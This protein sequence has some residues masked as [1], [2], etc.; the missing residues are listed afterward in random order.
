MGK[1][2]EPGEGQWQDA[3]TTS[4]AGIRDEAD[5]TRVVFEA[6]VVERGSRVASVGGVHHGVSEERWSGHRP[7]R[8]G[9]AWMG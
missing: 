9:A 6:R 3:E 5:A 7:G 8:T 1:C 4:S 2:A